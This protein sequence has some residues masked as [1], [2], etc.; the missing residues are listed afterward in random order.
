M[1]EAITVQMTPKGLLIPLDAI[2][3]WVE[4]GVEVFREQQRIVIRPRPDAER[5]L[6]G[7]SRA[8]LTDVQILEAEGLL[9][10][11]APSPAQGLSLERFRELARSFSVGK[12]LS[13]MVIEERE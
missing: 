6:A 2:R 10:P 13:E 9:L 8:H 1:S 12:P 5:P 3:D 11:V 4:H 7:L